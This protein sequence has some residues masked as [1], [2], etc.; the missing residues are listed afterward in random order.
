MPVPQLP[1]TEV[2]K[3]LSTVALLN[4]EGDAVISCAE[5]CNSCLEHAYAFS[6]VVY[7]GLAGHWLMHQRRLLFHILYMG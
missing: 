2:D 7:S 4:G 3:L 6:L 1:L 5:P